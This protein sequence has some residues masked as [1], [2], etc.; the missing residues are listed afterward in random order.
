MR[1]EQ[2]F[3]KKFTFWAIFFIAAISLYAWFGGGLNSQGLQALALGILIFVVCA[4]LGVKVKQ[5]WLRGSLMMGMIL[6]S[7]YFYLSISYFRS[8]IDVRLT[9]LLVLA[10][11]VGVALTHS[12][13]SKIMVSKTVARH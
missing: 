8:R 5:N 12:A 6:I 11:L 2:S 7:A 13:I 3:L 10:G 4:Y 1:I 9:L